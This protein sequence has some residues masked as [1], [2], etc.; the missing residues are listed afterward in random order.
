[1]SG[2]R[3]AVRHKEVHDDDLDDDN[4]SALSF[5]III[6]GIR[7]IEKKAYFQ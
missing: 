6:P 2:G 1:V 5:E 7:R 4:E 3:A